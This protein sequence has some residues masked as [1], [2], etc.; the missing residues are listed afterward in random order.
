M[1]KQFASVKLLVVDGEIDVC[2]ARFFL[3]MGQCNFRYKN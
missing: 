2:S 3:C 1:H